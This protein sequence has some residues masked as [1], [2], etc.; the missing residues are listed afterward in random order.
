MDPLMCFFC[1]SGD[2]F[3]HVMDVPHPCSSSLYRG[4]VTCGRCGMTI[5]GPVDTKRDEAMRRCIDLW[6]S[7]GK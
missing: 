4:E 6:N 5:E 3:V 1:G 2:V 7:K